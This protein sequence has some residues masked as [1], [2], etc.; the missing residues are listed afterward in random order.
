MSHARTSLALLLLLVPSLLLAGCG[1][2]GGGGNSGGG[3]NGG[4]NSVPGAVTGTVVDQSGNPVPA[5]IVLL[6]GVQQNGATYQKGGYR[7]D[8]V[9]PGFHIITAQATVSGQT[10]TGSTQVYVILFDPTNA[11]SLAN[12]NTGANI[13]LSPPTEQ[14]TVDGKVVNQS[15]QGVPGARVFF[16]V[17]TAVANAGSNPAGAAS[18]VGFTDANGNYE[19]Y[20]FP[21]INGSDTPLPYTVA[22]SAVP[23]G[24]N[25]PVY[26]TAISTFQVTTTQA[27]AVKS[28]QTTPIAGP[29]FTLTP[30]SSGGTQSAPV[31]NF[32]QAFTQPP[33]YPDATAHT[34]AAG[35]T[36]SATNTSVYEQIRRALSPTYARLAAA[37]HAASSIK[38]VAARPR[39]TYYGPYAVQ[40]DLFFSVPGDQPNVP[41]PERGSLAGFTI[42]NNL[43][44]TGQPYDVLLDP[45]ANFYTDPD[46]AP[47]SLGFNQTYA[48]GQKYNFSVSGLLTDGSTT[49]AQSNSLSIAPLNVL[50]LS[51][52]SDPDNQNGKV[53]TLP[54]PVTINWNA[55][56][57]APSGTTYSVFIYSQFP[58]VTVQPIAS[59]TG[60][61]TTSYAP[62][63]TFTPGAEYWLVVAA[64]D[65]PASNESAVSVS[66]IVPFYVQ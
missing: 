7:L 20:N 10:Y 4:G 57:G 15:G 12:T 30:A 66:Q 41:S 21:V 48:A 1:G 17:P 35:A 61:T 56:L 64:S 31:L 25:G 9:S 23:S 63:V 60:L 39:V 26:T 6:D 55:V 28:G 38:H 65:S 43:V 34:Q 18:E 24:S 45:L 46:L 53:T 49:T 36:A 14:A 29:N 58:S 37:G 2:G 59:A 42:Y 33:I 44:T 8:G 19:I 27:Q 47:A 40:M 16:Q 13:Q 62:T 3:G 32:L 5:A 22:A 52:P 54:T 51:Q 11:T 50:T